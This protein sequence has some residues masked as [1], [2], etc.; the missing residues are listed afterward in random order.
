MQ[1][2]VPIKPDTEGYTG[3]ECPKCER[4]FKIKFGTGLKG[5]IPCHCPYCNH[6]GPQSEFWDREQ[7]EYAKS[8]ALNRISGDVLSCLKKLEVKPKTGQFMSIGIEVK[9][10][11]S[12][13]ANYSEKELEQEV[14]CSSCTL[15]YTI[16]GAFGYCPDCGV[17]NSQQILLA[18]FDVILKMLDL[19]ASLSAGEVAAKLVENALEDA[20]S[21]FDGFGR[22]CCSKVVEKISFQNIGA[23]KDRLVKE[24][25]ID[26]S[27]GLDGNDWSFLVRQFQKRHLLAHKMGIV[28]EEYLKKTESDASILGRKV[29][30]SGD[31]VVK[32]I[33]QLKMMADALFRGVNGS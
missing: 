20:V 19:V 11:P 26:L 32:L 22:E 6:C 3:R 24:C 10:R 17:H 1:F 33:N 27:A 14:T 2:S 15:E 7:I 21:S 5:N 4:Y 23:A 8:V 29:S 28:D 18:N 12:Y 13:I 25:G 16:Y 31:D 9:G 30:I